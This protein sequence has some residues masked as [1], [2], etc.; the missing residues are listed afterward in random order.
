MEF[1]VITDPIRATEPWFPTI[2][3]HIDERLDI[4]VRNNYF[5][6]RRDC[7]HLFFTQP[8]CHLNSNKY[9]LNKNRH[10]KKTAKLVPK[11]LGT[12]AQ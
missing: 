9:P 11:A 2:S 12:S 8:Q 3:R 4:T 10:V 7:F 5:S 6:T 1:L